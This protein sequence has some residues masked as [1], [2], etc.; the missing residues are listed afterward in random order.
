MTVFDFD[1]PDVGIGSLPS[2]QEFGD[3]IG[4]HRKSDLLDPTP[5][6]RFI[7]GRSGGRAEQM[8]GP[9]AMINDHVDG[10][11]F[12]RTLPNDGAIDAL[13]LTAAQKRTY[14]DFGFQSHRRAR[15]LLGHNLR[16]ATQL[17]QFGEQRGVD[18][19]GFGKAAVM[20]EPLDRI[21]GLE[22]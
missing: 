17:F 10:A 7:V 2:C 9:I 8:Q 4:R 3:C 20:R 21:A 11:R 22:R 12:Q 19:A 16:L 5:L 13:R 15:L 6:A 18:L 14:P 1:D